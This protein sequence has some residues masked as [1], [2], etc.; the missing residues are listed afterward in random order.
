LSNGSV[1]LEKNNFIKYFPTGFYVNLCPEENNIEIVLIRDGNEYPDITRSN[2]RLSN[3]KIGIRLLRKL[4]FMR[5][6][7]KF[8]GQ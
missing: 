8:F 2:I 3:T 1:V 6:M 5:I 4:F 7:I